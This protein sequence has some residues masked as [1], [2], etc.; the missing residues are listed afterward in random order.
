MTEIIPCIYEKKFPKGKITIEGSSEYAKN[1]EITAMGHLTLALERLINDDSHPIC[2]DIGANIGLTTILMDQMFSGGRI[3]SFEPH[4]KTHSQLTRNIQTNCSDKNKIEIFQLALGANNEELLFRDIDTYNTGNSLLIKG[5][6]AARAQNVISVPV[7][8]LDDLKIAG[9]ESI[10]LLKIDVEG[11]EIDVLKGGIETLKRA[12]IV[13]L[14]FNH[15]CL[16]SIA[17]VFPED[18]LEYVFNLFDAVFVYNLTKKSYSRISTDVEKW[19]FLHK[20]MVNFN[21][22][23]LLCTNKEEVINLLSE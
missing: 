8:R 11:F 3:Y 6:L 4:P 10:R 21:V 22:N 17:K 7:K 16:S 12:D 15:W 20:N 13:L 23:D 5:S 2:L 9:E 19:S 14:E 18:A 1:V